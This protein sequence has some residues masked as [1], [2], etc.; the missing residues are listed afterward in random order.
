MAENIID[1]I[2]VSSYSKV[3]AMTSNDKVNSLAIIRFAEHFEKNEMFQISSKLNLSL[4]HSLTGRPLFRENLNYLA[5]EEYFN[6]GAR[7]V[8]IPVT[9]EFTRAD[10]EM[11]YG[12]DSLLLFTI[13]AKN[14]LAVVTPE[15]PKVW[16]SKIRSVV[17]LVAGENGPPGIIQA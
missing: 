16:P 6:K 13:D 8:N 17:A 9:S 3:L 5:F 7:A 11:K 4:P 2:E 10:F 15:H 14:R 12:K 1:E